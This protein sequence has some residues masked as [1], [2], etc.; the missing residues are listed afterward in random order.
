[1]HEKGRDFR[2]NPRLGQAVGA[3][4][5]CGWGADCRLQMPFKLALAV[6]GPVAGH[7]LGALRE[8]GGCGFPPF[9]CIP[10]GGGDLI[11]KQ[12]NANQR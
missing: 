10:G 7:R 11:K 6:R 9:P 8:G 2:G 5:R 3:G 4:C 12:T 1:M